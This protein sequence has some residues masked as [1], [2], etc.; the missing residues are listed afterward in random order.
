MGTGSGQAYCP[1]QDYSI[2]QG[3]GHGSFYDSAPVEDDFPVKEM[4]PAKAK[5][6]LKRAS[7]A[8][9]KDGT[10]K[11]QE[12]TLWTIEEDI[13]LCKAWCDVLENSVR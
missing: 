10:N 8:N 6:P 5:K 7:K 2:G 4:S 13:A 12:P 3:S 1:T 11:D 9:K